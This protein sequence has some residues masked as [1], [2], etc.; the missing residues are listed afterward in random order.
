M[1]GLSQGVMQH[2]ERANTHSLVRSTKSSF[3]VF[4]LFQIHTHVSI[5]FR[6]S[7]TGS[8]SANTRFSPNIDVGPASQRV[9]QH[10]ANVSCLPGYILTS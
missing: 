5:C 7:L 1:N 4:L 10:W 2:L 8:M 9:G 6:L 3:N